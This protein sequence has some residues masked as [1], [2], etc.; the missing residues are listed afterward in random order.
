M[1]II[2]AIVKLTHTA[3]H[4]PI[5]H[6]QGSYNSSRNSYRKTSTL[7]Y[8]LETL[9]TLSTRNKKNPPRSTLLRKHYHSTLTHHVHSNPNHPHIPR[10]PVHDPM[11]PSLRHHR[12]CVNSHNNHP[13]PLPIPSPLHL[14][15][16][17]NPPLLRHLQHLRPPL[18]HLHQP[19]HFLLL[20]LLLHCGL[21][22]PTPRPPPRRL[23]SLPPWHLPWR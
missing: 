6:C 9:Y 14:L 21:L 12:H 1:A 5:E 20:L 13:R 2:A 18:L 8:V 15:K 16:H 10:R 23:S 11:Y 22:T 3:Q 7:F 4:C 19:Q 17:Q